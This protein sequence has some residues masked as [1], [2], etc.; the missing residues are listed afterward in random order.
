MK[1]IKIQTL[2]Y[3]HFFMLDIR[4]PHEDPKKFYRVFHWWTD[5]MPTGTHE[6]ISFQVCLKKASFATPAKNIKVFKNNYP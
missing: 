6:Q 3:P 4:F 1:N 2:E 5:E